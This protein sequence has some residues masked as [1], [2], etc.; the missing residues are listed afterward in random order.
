MQLLPAT[1]REVA[2]R[3][4]IS[5]SRGLGDPGLNLEIAAA[6]IADLMSEFGGR[7][8][9]VAAADS[10]GPAKA[11]RWIRGDEGADLWLWTEAIPYDVVRSYAREVA[12][13]AAI[14]AAWLGEPPPAAHIALPGV[15]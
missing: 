2:A 15:R 1:A 9:V 14:Y 10:A 8:E 11:R 3:H 6:M 4:G 7:T 13:S 12:V 5:L